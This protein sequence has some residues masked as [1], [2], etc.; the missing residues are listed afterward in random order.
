MDIVTIVEYYSTHFA[1]NVVEFAAWAPIY[2][3]IGAVSALAAVLTFLFVVFRREAGAV[4][5]SAIVQHAVVWSVPFIWGAL[6]PLLGLG[7]VAPA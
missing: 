5:V 3:W 4:A 7:G 2:G 1:E 6:A